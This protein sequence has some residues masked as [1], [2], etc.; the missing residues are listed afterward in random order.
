MWNNT[1]V[2]IVDTVITYLNKFNLTKETKLLILTHL[3]ASNLL[4]SFPKILQLTKRDW[5]V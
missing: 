3:W 2:T 1:K 5:T 4:V